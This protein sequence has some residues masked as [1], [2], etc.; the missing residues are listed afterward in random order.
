MTNPAPGY[1]YTFHPQTNATHA[2]RSSA[3]D[4]WLTEVLTVHSGDE[5]IYQGTRTIDG[6]PVKVYR[7]KD[8]TAYIAQVARCPR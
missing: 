7:L 5:W 2:W 8:T 1:C 4:D 3:D 6:S